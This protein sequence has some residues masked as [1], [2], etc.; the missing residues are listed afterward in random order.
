MY[1][2]AVLLYPGR[3][4]SKSVMYLVLRTQCYV[5]SVMY[6]VL[7]TQCYVLSVRCATT[8]QALLTQLN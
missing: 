5:L 4:Y 6:S 2:S 8:Y 3:D 7:R 1:K